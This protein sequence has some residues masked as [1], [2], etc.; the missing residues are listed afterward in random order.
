M[1]VLAPIALCSPSPAQQLAA[2]GADEQDAT[3][4]SS[5]SK[6]NRNRTRFIIGLERTVDFQVFALSNPN[7]VFVELPDVKLQ[8]PMLPGDAPVGL[9][10]SFRGGVSAPGKARV[11]IDVTGPVVIERSTIE[12]D[13]KAVPTRARDGGGRRVATVAQDGRPATPIGAPYGL[14]A[15]SLQPPVPKP[16]MSPR[17]RSQAV[18]R[19]VIVIDPGHGGDDTGAMGHGTVEKDVVLAFESEAS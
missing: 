10:K 15:A 12:R 8:L 19:P 14:G 18:Y 9:V 2:A 6:A 3:A 7:G 13:G 11:V 1:L 17:L 16:A 4:S 5:A